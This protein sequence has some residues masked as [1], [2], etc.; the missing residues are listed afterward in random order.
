MRPF[1]S[2]WISPRKTFEFLSTR[3]DSENSQTINILS[4]LITIGVSI[5]RLKEFAE[6]FENLK[7]VGLI[8]G[9]LFGS[10]LS[11][12]IGILI[13]RFIL[14][15]TYWVIG[16]MLNGKATKDQI[17]LVVAYSLIPYLIYLA[18]GLILIIPAL[19][20]QN[21]DLVFYRH[22]FTYFVVWILALRN[23]VYGLSYFNQ[24]SYGYAL[25]NIIIPL[26]VTE[27]LAQ[28][29]TNWRS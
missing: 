7:F 25:L 9:I 22:P 18:I 12:L 13:I 8:M 28:I 21:L 20:T 14:A 27:F 4:A 3:D 11:S 16:K 2:I 19:I 24:F 17:Q 5:P 26:G 1:F 6:L 29:V 23:L 10:L 15:L